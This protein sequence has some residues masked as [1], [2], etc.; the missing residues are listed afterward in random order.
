MLVVGL[1]TLA[2]PLDSGVNVAFPEITRSFGLSI[3]QI[4]WVVIVFMLAQTSLMM[5]FGRL[6]DMIGHRRVFLAGSALS[7]IA[8][9]A[10]ATAPSYNWLLAGR[11]AQGI[12]AGLI[13]SCG[14]A[15]AV[16]LKHESM[17]SR[18]LGHYTMLYS[19]G[20]VLGPAIAGLLLARFGWQSVFWFRAPI[21]LL[22]FVTSWALPTPLRART[23]DRFDVAGAS[24]L[25]F[26]ISMAVLAVDRLQHLSDGAIWSAGAACVSAL[27]F[28]AFAYQ[29][30]RTPQPIFELRHFKVAGF[31]R[32][33]LAAG[34]INL[35]CFS[36]LLLL[37]F[38][39]SHAVGLDAPAVGAILACSAAGMVIA[40]PLAGALATRVGPS[41][42]VRVGCIAMA[43]GLA[44]IATAPPLT[45]LVPALLLQGFGQG[46]FQVAYLDIVILTLPTTARGVAGSLTM[47][48][49][50]IGV[51]IGASVLTLAFQSLRTAAAVVTASDSFLS[52][53]Q[54]VFAIAAAIPA[55]SAVILLGRLPHKSPDHLAR[56]PAVDQ[57]LSAGNTGALSD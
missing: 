50:T 4:Q 56:Y 11:I 18:V 7:V 5:V 1:G 37:P 52:A 22:A 43:A 23:V 48:T 40:S 2:A 36:V 44:V 45:V 54:G 33:N 29:E 3:P 13:L 16:S 57:E 39:L 46:L 8:F 55:I 6:G 26:G 15:L 25:V 27:A 14:A 17:R 32:L 47:L 28:V 20:F 30:Q 49:R 9:A 51:V 53:F 34:L 41:A 31:T 42:L 12:G 35:A 21:A 19:F 38:Y 10:C 24:L